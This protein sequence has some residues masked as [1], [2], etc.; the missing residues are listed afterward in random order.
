MKAQVI[1]DHL[2]DS[3][4]SDLEPVNEEFPDEDILFTTSNT[5]QCTNIN[6]PW[7]VYFD[8]AVNKHGKGV[9]AVLES[10]WGSK[11]PAS[12][13]IQFECTNNMAEYEACVLELKMALEQNVTHLLVFGDSLLIISQIKGELKTKDKKLISYFEYLEKLVEEFVEIEFT[14][15]PRN[16]N[17][18]ADALATLAA[19]IELTDETMTIQIDSHKEPSY[20]L[21]I[22][23]SKSHENLP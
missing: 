6:L 17:S 16:R 2:A 5:S 3:A 11:Y 18:Y 23:T 13:K 7:K 21:H 1:A 10:L 19:W 22:E 15:L 20:C 12:T 9:G 14:Y 4:I 8:G